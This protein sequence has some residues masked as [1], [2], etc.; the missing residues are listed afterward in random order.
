MPL[1]K[2]LLPVLF[3][4]LSQ[5]IPF[6]NTPALIKRDVPNQP[7]AVPPNEGDCY[8][9]RF[10]QN[11]DHFGKRNGTFQQKYNLVT[12]FFK[13]GGPIFFYQGEEQVYMDCVDTSI[14]YSWAQET[15]GIAVILEH[16]YFG[17]SAPF[18]ATDP[19]TQQAEFQYLTLD[20]VMADAANFLSYLKKNVTGA[21]DSKVIVFSG[22]F[23]PVRLM[24]HFLICRPGSYGGFLSTVFR[25][26][27]PDTIFGAIASAPPAQGM[28]NNTKT[29]GFFNWNIWVSHR[30]MFRILKE[31]TA[32]DS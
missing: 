13:P 29:P 4:L 26:N 5:A 22:M 1:L 20:N 9:Q 2:F 21:E 32:L 14:G 11:I 8:F 23:L 18:N 31:L 10:T 19:A 25:Q 6:E 28:G 3:P 15:N 27:M 24:S 12:D 16:R 17:Q 7:P 30:V